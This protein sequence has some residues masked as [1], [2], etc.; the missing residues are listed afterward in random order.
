MNGLQELSASTYPS[1]PM[2]APA[3]DAGIRGP[4]RGAN[5]LRTSQS[6]LPLYF[7]EGMP[8]LPSMSARQGAELSLKRLFDVVGSAIA[9][10][11]LLPLFAVVAVAIKMTS[12]GPAF[13]IQEREGL[14]GRRFRCIKFRSMHVERG[15]A[16]GVEQTVKD[17]PRVFALGRLIR[18]TSID[19]LP[20]LINVLRG[21]MSLVGPR[22]HVP[23]MRAGGVLY[24]DLVPY[25]DT[26]LVVVPGLTGWAQVNGLRGP[27]DNADLARTRVDHDIA[28]V[29]NYSLWLDTKIV[30]K[31]LVTEFVSGSGH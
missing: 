12:P 8:V 28:Y 16:S 17:D 1:S 31:T 21:E 24:R 2:R 25:Y 5:T 23:G 4:F 9:L 7:R 20:Q 26:R 18:R 6:G 30:L 13:F 22:P 29:A 27:T 11:V 15:D 19:E 3:A 10:I 14:N